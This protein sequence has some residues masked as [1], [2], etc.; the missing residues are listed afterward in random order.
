MTVTKREM[1]GI[2]GRL[3]VSLLRLKEENKAL[4]NSVCLLH[5]RLTRCSGQ[6]RRLSR[7]YRKLRAYIRTLRRWLSAEETAT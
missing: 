5:E 4:Q 3:Q 2:N 1:E 7:Q 6:A